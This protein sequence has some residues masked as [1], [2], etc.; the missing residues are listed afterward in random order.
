MFQFHKVS[1]VEALDNY[2]LKVKFECGTIKIYNVCPMFDKHS[3]FNELKKNSLFQAVY[4]D[5]AGYGVIWNEHIDL[6][7]NELWYKGK[8][9]HNQNP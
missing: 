2:N 7:C 9:I 1:G 8:E 4:V 3:I 5:S 6:A